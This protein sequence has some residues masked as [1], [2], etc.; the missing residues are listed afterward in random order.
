MV[1][2]CLSALMIYNTPEK[3]NQKQHPRMAAA[4][5][6]DGSGLEIKQRQSGYEAFG[7]MNGDEGVWIQAQR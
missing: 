5:T 2:F 3:K 1:S 6:M 4:W 7:F